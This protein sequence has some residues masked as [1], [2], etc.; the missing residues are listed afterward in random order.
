MG[1]R[2][3]IWHESGEHLGYEFV[4]DLN[5][6]NVGTQKGVQALGSLITYLKR[7][8]YSAILGLAAE[9]DDGAAAVAEF[10]ASP[11]APQKPNTPVTKPN[12]AASPI[13]TKESLLEFV[14]HCFAKTSREKRNQ[15]SNS[16]NFA[17]PDVGSMS[18]QELR[19][20]KEQL[21]AK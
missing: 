17:W 13:E 6:Q 8:H 4:P 16:L 21:D 2:T 20:I 19:E 5:L 14:R 7:Y 11:K 10:K 15:I 18:I 9:D 12:L 1:I 3:E